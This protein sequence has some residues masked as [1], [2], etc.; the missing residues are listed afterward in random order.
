MEAEA[1]YFLQ[2]IGEASD[3]CSEED[4]TNAQS[5]LQVQGQEAGELIREGA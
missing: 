5:L 4:R 2:T 1:T 3:F